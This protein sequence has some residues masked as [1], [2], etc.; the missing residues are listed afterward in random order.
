MLAGMSESR[1]VRRM[2]GHTTTIFGEMSALAARTG[3]VNL[4]QGFPDTD[5]PELLKRSA[6]RAIESGAG[7][8]YPPAH[9]YGVLRDAIAE[10]Q[11][12]FYGLVVD[13]ATDVVVTT[14]ASEALG[15]AVMALVEPGEEVIVLEPWF[16][17]YAAVISLAG[18][19][20]VAVPP[21][22]TV[23]PV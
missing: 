22:M 8:Q 6:I 7:N 5:G 16:D 9:G 3:S 2:A 12:N 14:G 11:Q 10:H 17:L 4:G 13:P 15:A 18:A 19:V 20:K 23:P 1:L 21:L